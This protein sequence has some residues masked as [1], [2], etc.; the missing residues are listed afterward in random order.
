MSASFT[1]ASS[2]RVRRRTSLRAR[3]LALAFAAVMAFGVAVLS[4]CVMESGYSASEG[5]YP[6]GTDSSSV[7]Y[8]STGAQGQSSSAATQPQAGTPIQIDGLRDY[9]VDTS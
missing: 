9:Y 1:K 8:L 4:G 3:L 6:G 5:F 2:A 7:G